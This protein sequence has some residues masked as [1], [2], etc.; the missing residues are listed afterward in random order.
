MDEAARG[1]GGGRKSLKSRQLVWRQ[2]GGT[3][4]AETR[5]VHDT[6]RI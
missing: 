3:Q 1:E 2:P 6:V 5:I 4:R